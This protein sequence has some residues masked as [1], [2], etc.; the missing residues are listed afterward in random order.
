[1]ALIKVA[2]ERMYENKRAQAATAIRAQTRQT[3]V[4]RRGC[5][6]T[7]SSEC[8]HP[9]LEPPSVSPDGREVPWALRSFSFEIIVIARR[10]LEIAS[11]Q[12]VPI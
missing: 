8:S 11:I 9:I 2:D 5:G 10:R 6:R 1:M 3:R 12:L 7:G 4:S